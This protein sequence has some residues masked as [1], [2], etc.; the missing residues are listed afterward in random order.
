MS[1][2]FGIPPSLIEAVKKVK[3]EKHPEDVK[4]DAN[5]LE[6]EGTKKWLAAD[7]K[8]KEVKEDA[9]ICAVC[10]HDP[11]I[12]E[13]GQ[14][15]KEAEGGGTAVRDVKD[16][17][18]A[19]ADRAKIT[20]Q[21]AMLRIKQAKEREALSKK[22]KSIKESFTPA[23]IDKLKAEYSGISTIDPSSPA[24]KKLVAMLDK[25]DTKTLESLAGAKIKFVSSLAQNR[26]NR[27]KMKKEATEY[28]T[29][30]KPLEKK[31]EKSMKK[32]GTDAKVDCKTVGNVSICSE[33]N[34]E[35]DEELS[36]KQK[37]IDKNKNGKIDG[38]DL[39]K[40]RGEELSAKQKAL[41]KNKNGK[42]DGSD[43]AKLRKEET[44]LEEKTDYEVYHKDYSSAVQTAI[45]QAEKRG[46]EV[47]MDDW[48]DKV[49]TGPKKPSSGKTNSFSIK[50]MKDGKPSKKALQMQ[51]YNMDNHKYELNMYIESVEEASSPAQQAA[52]AIAMKKAGKKPK[53]MEESDAYDKDVK[54]KEPPSDRDTITKRA[55]LA[56]LAARKKVTEVTEKNVNDLFAEALEKK[57]GAKGEQ[58]AADNNKS[59]A[60]GDKLTGKKEPIEIEPEL[61]N[62]NK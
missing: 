14:H 27:A 12:C 46:Y 50:L 26:V 35:I 6:P 34:P 55:K 20:L 18:K 61:K 1:F 44:E 7:Y 33:F 45:K 59:V 42:I 25:L 23:Q 62:S 21:S 49:A 15:I 28:K 52:I 10:E 43:L 41:D 13:T 30:G 37:Q 48:H 29:G 17:A 53:D 3:N 19:Q 36:A 4:T 47:D 54:Q 56:A 8:K 32:L 57:K 2:K 22:K 38:S 39:A 16:Q 5:K 51:V 9:N 31:F 24:Y 58:T 11:C 60:K 40:L